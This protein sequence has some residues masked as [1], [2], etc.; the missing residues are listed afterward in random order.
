MRTATI[1]LAMVL[2]ACTT[3]LSEATCPLDWT[4][5]KL[6]A[7]NFS[8]CYPEKNSVVTSK[9]DRNFKGARIQNYV[10]EDSHGQL[11]KGEYHLELFIWDHTQGKKY[12]RIENSVIYT[13]C[14][15][16]L[17]QK[18]S[19][20][21]SRIIG[22]RGIE[23]VYESSGTSFALCIQKPGIDIY[24]RVTERNPEGGIANKILDSFSID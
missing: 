24:L 18:K 11:S 16:K 20:E 22:H 4:T 21:F 10:S 7:Y 9:D 19:V 1:I 14:S 2:S 17:T 12:A 15:D 6:D 3:Q 13:S 23:D 5:Y 8:F